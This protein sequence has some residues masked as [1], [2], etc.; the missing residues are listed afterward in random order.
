MRSALDYFKKNILHIA[1][2]LILCFV[3]VLN[4][5]HTRRTLGELLD[6]GSFIAAGRAVTE[7]K[8]PYSSDL[9]FVYSV[10]SDK[11]PTTIASP[12]LN[13]PVSVLLFSLFSNVD[14]R[15][16]VNMWRVISG[17]LYGVVIFILSINFRENLSP[18][19]IVWAFSLAGIWNIVLL[20]QIYVPLLLLVT[21]TWV[22]LEK[23]HFKSAGIAIGALIAIKPNFLVWLFLLLISKQRIVFTSA[24]VTFIIISA[25]PLP[26][27]GID[28]YQ[29]WIAAATNYPSIGLYIAGNSSLQSLG[30]RLGS[31]L[32][33]WIL[34]L[35]LVS[36]ITMLAVKQQSKRSVINSLGIISSLLVFPFTWVGYTVMTLPVFF[37]K[38]KWDWPVTVSAFLLAFPYLLVLRFFSLSEINSVIF[39]W[40][41]GWALLILIVFHA[42]SPAAQNSSPS[43]AAFTLRTISE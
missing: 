3:N 15:I 25:L 4:I 29:Q 10:V 19:L 22:C 33:G 7:G 9:P 27:F 12:N 28:I 24:V 8:N 35:M 21:I 34:A 17:L 38:Q 30:T 18:L 16:M 39:G 2:I 13:P 32:M 36:A 43:E 23:G 6:F 37:S 20:G 31:P 42:V 5:F 41:Y 1:A 26:F 14:P 40:I 11:S